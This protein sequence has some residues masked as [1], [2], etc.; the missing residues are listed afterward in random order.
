MDRL[1]EIIQNPHKSSIS[2]PAI[3][4][5][6]N[7]SAISPGPNGTG[8]PG[9]GQGAPLPGAARR[10]LLAARRIDKI[11]DLEPFFGGVSLAAYEAVYNSRNGMVDWDAVERGLCRE[12]FEG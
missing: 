2:T 12:L 9:Q 10:P 5:S 8:R 3:Y 1:G 4:Q 7:L 6:P 11:A